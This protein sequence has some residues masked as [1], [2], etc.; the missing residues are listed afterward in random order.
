MKKMVT[1]PTVVAGIVIGYA[2]L[3]A[4]WLRHATAADLTGAWA[5]DT[6]ACAKVF[7]KTGSR[8]A[9]AR[10]SDAHGSGFIIEGNRIRGKMATCTIKARKQDGQ[11]VNLVTT[12][13][14][15]IAVETIQFMLKVVDQDRI[16]RL[17]PGMPELEASYERCS[18][19]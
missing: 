14:T 4:P 10:N 13:S 2:V 15:D 3:N 12:C 1:G 9:F 11:I 6:S 7:H 5:N 18:L 8:I 17:F 16:T 19:Y